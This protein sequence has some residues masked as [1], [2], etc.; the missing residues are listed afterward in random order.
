MLRT[1]KVVY[2]LYCIYIVFLYVCVCMPCTRE[3]CQK[4]LTKCE[5]RMDS[6]FC[7]RSVL[8]HTM[9]TNGL[10]ISYNKKLSVPKRTILPNKYWIN[11]KREREI[12]PQ[13]VTN[14]R[15]NVLHSY[16]YQ[17]WYPEPNIYA[18]NLPLLHTQTHPQ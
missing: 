5:K 12:K 16:S 17:Y 18:T 1:L 3:S 14:K 10:S 7:D 6:I 2:S 13:N 4:L 15:I 8:C 9:A 11:E